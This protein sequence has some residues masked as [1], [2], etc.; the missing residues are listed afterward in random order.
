MPVLSIESNR[1]LLG[2]NSLNV[3][4]SAVANM[5]EKPENYVMVKYQHNPDML[6]A[7]TNEA[8]AFLELKSLALPE[9][10]TAL[11]S[12]N[13]VEVMHDE[14]GVPAERLYIEFTSPDRHMFGWNGGTFQNTRRR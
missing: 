9:N 7:G 11:F 4:S 3:I 10:K 1:P 2:D 8:V 13:L 14:L 5:L 12:A 6:F